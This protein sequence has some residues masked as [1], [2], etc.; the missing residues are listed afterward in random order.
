MDD[1]PVLGDFISAL[2][3]EKNY[4]GDFFFNKIYLKEHQNAAQ[5]KK[6]DAPGST[7]IEK[8]LKFM[9]T[10]YKIGELFFEYMYHRCC[11]ETSKYCSFCSDQG[12]TS[13]LPIK[14]VPQPIPEPENPFHFKPVNE[15][16]NADANG[17]PRAPDDFQPRANIKK[18]VSEG[19]LSSQEEVEELC[20][21][22]KLGP[23]LHSAL[24]RFENSEQ[25]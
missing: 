22:A 18:L 1:A 3:A 24:R 23:S 25:Y 2:L 5:Q 13:P 11:T 16:P 21:G 6:T 10:H 14:G 15:T 8:I 17:R 19:A 20:C 4:C 12:W 7:Y 9:E